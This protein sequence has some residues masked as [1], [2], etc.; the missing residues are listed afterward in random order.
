MSRDVLAVRRTLRCLE[1]V[2]PEHRPLAVALQWAMSALRAHWAALHRF[3]DG[4]PRA[5]PQLVVSTPSP[6]DGG[7]ALLDFVA[8]ELVPEWLATL[9]T[10]AASGSRAVIANHATPS[11]ASS[12]PCSALCVPILDQ[13]GRTPIGTLTLLSNDVKRAWTTDEQQL[14]LT[15][16]PLLGLHLTQHRLADQALLLDGATKAPDEHGRGRSLTDQ[17]AKVV[18]EMRGAFAEKLKAQREEHRAQLRQQAAEHEE[19]TRQLHVQVEK[20]AERVAVAESD[21]ESTRRDAAVRMHRMLEGL[22]LQ[23]IAELDALRE[24]YAARGGTVGATVRAAVGAAPTAATAHLTPQ[25]PRSSCASPPRRPATP[26]AA[27]Q[28]QKTPS[29]CAAALLDPLGGKLVRSGRPVPSSASTVTS[30]PKTVRPLLDLPKDSKALSPPPPPNWETTVLSDGQ[31]I[32]YTALFPAEHTGAD[33]EEEGYAFY[34]ESTGFHEVELDI[35]FNGSTNV[36]LERV[37]GSGGGRDDGHFGPLTAR[38]KVPPFER[39]PLA[40]LVFNGGGDDVSMTYDLSWRI[41]EPD[42]KAVAERARDDREAIEMALDAVKREWR[43]IKINSRR[44]RSALPSA[45]TVRRLIAQSH[46]GSFL[47]VEFPPLVES[48]DGIASPLPT[49]ALMYSWRRPTDF[50]AIKQPPRVFVDGLLPSDVQQGAL[51]NCWFMCSVAAVA[52]FP[53]LVRSLFLEEWAERAPGGPSHDADGV[54]DLMFNKHGQWVHVRVDDYF[55]C[56]P[57]GGPAFSQAN[58]PELWVL[59]LEKAYAKLHGSYFSLRSGFGYEA[60]MDL[61][62]APTIYRRFDEDDV[63]FADIQRFDRLQCLITCS[64]PGQ[65]TISEDGDGRLAAAGSGLVPGHAYTLIGTAVLP[66]G[67]RYAGARLLKLRNPWGSFEWGGRFSD[68]SVEMSD[69]DVRRALYDDA[70]TDEIEEPAADDGTFFMMFDDFKQHFTSIAVCIAH[71]PPQEGLLGP[72]GGG[73]AA[74]RLRPHQ[75]A[76][77]PDVAAALGRGAVRAKT[78]G[79]VE[80]RKTCFTLGG[81]KAHAVEE[82]AH[83]VAPAKAYRARDWFTL[84]VE[85]PSGANPSARVCC[86]IGLHQVDERCEGAPKLLDV[87]LAVLEDFEGELI[88]RPVEAPDDSGV[89]RPC[90]LGSA[91]QRDA[92][93]IAHL[94]PG[95]YIIVPTSSGAPPVYAAD[96]PATELLRP[97][98]VVDATPELSTP[99]R[100]ALEHTAFAL[101]ADMDGL[102]GSSDWRQPWA[103]EFAEAACIDVYGYGAAAAANADDAAEGGMIDLAEHGGALSAADLSRVLG[104]QWGGRHGA[105]PRLGRLLRA[106]GYNA[107]LQPVAADHACVVSVHS[108]GRVRLEPRPVDEAQH[109]RVMCAII[110]ASGKKFVV[111]KVEVWQ[112]QTQGAVSYAAVNTDP[113]RAAELTIDCSNSTNVRSD[114]AML[115]STIKLPPDRTARQARL[116]LVLVPKD[117]R[118]PWT[119]TAKMSAYVP[120]QRPTAVDMAAPPPAAAR[121][122]PTSA[123]KPVAAAAAKPMAALSPAQAPTAAAAAPE[124]AKAPPSTPVAS[125]IARPLPQGENAA[126]AAAA[127]GCAIA[128]ARPATAAAGATKPVPVAAAKPM[129]ADKPALAPAQPLSRPVAIAMQPSEGRALNA[130]VGA[131]PLRSLS[132]C[133]LSS[134]T[135]LDESIDDPT[136]KSLPWGAL[137]GGA[138]GGGALGGGALGGVALGGVALGGA[139][140]ALGVASPLTAPR[141]VAAARPAPLAASA[142][143]SAGAR[144]IAAARPVTGPGEGRPVARAVAVPVGGSC[145]GAV[146]VARAQA[147]ARSQS[148]G[149]S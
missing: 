144:P 53:A 5:K 79:S 110:R 11:L 120:K 82:L 28:A 113:Q 78:A 26:A 81:S 106:A 60:L 22:E 39:K 138:F 57:S 71:V 49:T 90:S 129:A 88:E 16:G 118:E 76:M 132:P 56:R 105:R 145:G 146:P 108:T 64:T 130:S 72:G 96:V 117:R 48:I 45:D 12:A 17:A 91:V 84:R 38:V 25:P 51:G 46:I 7:G 47:D 70:S 34:L 121:P 86:M 139:G 89:K 74:Q 65:D 6:N 128:V 43:T 103:H 42:P 95:E 13:D 87:G 142:V 112:L 136:S 141:A 44:E 140:R 75:V 31:A 114:H 40:R 36:R 98:A 115:S 124:A 18:H 101:D 30:Q 61:T 52:E 50:L 148:S 21:A 131:S 69:P 4:N 149:E 58:G 100:R 92:L 20:L 80:R 23:H 122:V 41:K 66:E 143:T 19:A 14:L 55:P 116:V 94:T 59:L 3:A 109:E 127:A 67:T 135:R 126:A 29:K 63:S 37:A 24:D 85:A 27:T 125:A 104:Q 83:G 2:T 133:S 107:A 35:D 102:V 68:N 8:D 62:G 32:L 137:G 54:Y 134:S 97:S 73:E 147:V 123:A 77:W 99:V 111:G 15:A 33:G 93:L 9:V 10:K 1:T 119:F